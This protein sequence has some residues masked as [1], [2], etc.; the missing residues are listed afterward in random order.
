MAQ[1][2]KVH[3]LLAP[4]PLMLDFA[5]PAEVLRRANKIQSEIIFDVQYIAP[6]DEMMTSAGL[7]V[8]GLSKLP[9]QL[10]PNCFLM[11]SGTTKDILG[12]LPSPS[13]AQR[14]ADNEKIV[15]WLR[16][17][18][19]AKQ[20][21][22]TICSGA[23]LA[24]RAGLFDGY[25]CTTHHDCL[26]ELR[27]IS[28][29]IKIEEN[30]LF[31]EDRNRFASAGITSGTDLMLHIVGKKLG[32]AAAAEIAKHMVVYAR[33]NGDAP[34]L[35]PW[36]QGRSHLHPTIHRIQD[37]I[38]ADPT[39]DWDV[40][41]LAKH[42]HMSARHFSRLFNNQTGL[43]VPDY[44][45]G[46]RIAIAENALRAEQINIEHLVGDLGFGSS[47]HFRRAWQKHHQL[48]PTQWRQS[49]QV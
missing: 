14:T 15:E 10:Q 22:L 44:V 4:N 9:N 16:A 28:P 19:T 2:I 43:S 36:L 48:S 27:S 5:G 1:H 20:T 46:L 34:Q 31:T 7:K 37:L 32:I 33:R 23:L 17:T 26:E 35:S 3:I 24:A 29:Q 21:L 42:A 39:K 30:R 45:N 11:V 25:R 41:S 6:R 40:G 47:R 8:S 49:Q 13:A 18:F 12:D 38:A